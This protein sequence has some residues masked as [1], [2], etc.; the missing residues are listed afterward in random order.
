MKLNQTSSKLKPKLNLA[1]Q[2]GQNLLVANN[3]DDDFLQKNISIVKSSTKGKIKNL[4]SPRRGRF[5]A[6][7]LD[8]NN[9][10]FIDSRLVSF[11]I[12]QPPSKNI[13]WPRIHRDIRLL[14]KSCPSFG[15]IPTPE[16]TNDETKIDFAGPFKIARSSKK[17]SMVSIDNKTGWQDVK[18]L[19]VPTTR[20]I[21]EV[22]QRY[23]A[24]NGIPTQIRT[25]P[26]FRYV[27]HKICQ[28][29]SK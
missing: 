17:C 11:K 13:W 5:H 9:L 4:E 15:K 20:E 1:N 7:S 3:L 23:I 10:L 12:L 29:F 25:D 26:I 21:I 24:D 14:A 28:M 27:I 2:I 18:F 8:E 16:E 19:Q 6:L 22:L